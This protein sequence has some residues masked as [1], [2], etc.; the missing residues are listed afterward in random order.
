MHQQQAR[1]ETVFN[2][3]STGG[4][5][6]I[7]ETPIYVNV[8]ELKAKF[9]L[10]SDHCASISVTLM[11]KCSLSILQQSI[12]RITKSIWDWVNKRWLWLSSTHILGRLNRK[13][14]KNTEKLS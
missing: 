5:F 12:A 1:A 13:A 3:A 11:S 9:T 2:N 14:M 7:T 8:L 4:Q 10:N 6:S